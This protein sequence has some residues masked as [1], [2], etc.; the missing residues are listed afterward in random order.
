MAYNFLCAEP[1]SLGPGENPACFHPQMWFS[2]DEVCGVPCWKSCHSHPW[3]VTLTV[4]LHLDT[5]CHIRSPRPLHGASFLLVGPQVVVT[6]A[7]PTQDPSFKESCSKTSQT[8][9][10]KR[11]YTPTN[12]IMN[13]SIHVGTEVGLILFLFFEYLFC[14]T[15]SYLQHV[16]SQLPD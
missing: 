9:R 14:C 1:A 7:S 2:R 13:A 4:H 8:V 5:P 12:P 3:T 15:R 10:P 16:G 11:T 6:A